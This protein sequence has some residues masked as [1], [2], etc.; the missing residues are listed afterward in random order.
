MCIHLVTQYRCSHRLSIDGGAVPH[1]NVDQMRLERD[2]ID[3]MASDG[4]RTIGVAFRDIYQRNTKFI[5][6][7]AQNNERNN[8]ENEQ[9]CEKSE[10][11]SKEI[12]D[13]ERESSDIAREKINSESVQSD[14]EIEDRQDKK[15]V[16]SHPNMGSINSHVDTGSVISHPHIGVNVSHPNLG[17]IDSHLEIDLYA[18]RKEITSPIIDKKPYPTK[19]KHEEIII[20]WNDEFAV[21]SKLTLLAI[22]GVE[23]P[24]RPEVRTT[25]VY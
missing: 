4:L 2:V 19:A 18:N 5:S 6:S 3:R 11:N 21:V 8:P 10:I 14:P 7:D 17:S 12:D 20:D 9:T 24:V 25:I 16:I 23:D 22:V 13:S 1:T 15:S